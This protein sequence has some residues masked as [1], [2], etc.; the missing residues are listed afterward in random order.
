MDE[1]YLIK[2]RF[3]I[4]GNS[5]LLNHAIE[6]AIQVAPTDLTVLIIGESGTGKEFF[7]KIIHTY[8]ARKHGPYIAVNCGAIPEGTIDSELFGH[9]KGSFTGAIDSRKGYF[10]VANGGL[11]F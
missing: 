5:P 11:F 6:V 7:P 2:Q 8:S 3:G 10:E 4:I 1:L 9:E